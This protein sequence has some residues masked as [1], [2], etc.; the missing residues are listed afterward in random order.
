MR[1][2]R[3]ATLLLTVLLFMA[4]VV[5]A[6]QQNK[7]TIFTFKDSVQVPGSVLPAGTYVF[8]LANSDANRHIVQIYNQDETKLITTILAAPNYQLQPSGETII[9]YTKAPANQ[10]LALEAWFYPGD[11]FGQQFIYPEGV[12]AELS[13]LNTIKVPSTG[14]EQAYPNSTSSDTMTSSNAATTSPS[15]SSNASATTPSSTSGSMSSNNASSATPSS[16]NYATSGS[17]ASATTPSSTTP[18]STEPTTPATSDTM[19]TN[20]GSTKRTDDMK[21]RSDDMATA[22]TTTPASRA[23]AQTD[24]SAQNMNSN[25]G[26]TSAY[27]SQNPDSGSQQAT[28]DTSA[29]SQTDRSQNLPQTGSPLPL[30]GLL[31]FLSISAAIV[32]RKLSL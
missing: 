13:T 6:D 31:G 4:G 9:S 28:S 27:S 8:K 32:L 24:A 25:S 26:R 3:I 15:S 22:T 1:N 20:M 16:S 23:T 17:S 12:A 11:N 30:A 5:S 2:F 19:S 10:P 18:S 29:Q 14:S 7:K 21:P